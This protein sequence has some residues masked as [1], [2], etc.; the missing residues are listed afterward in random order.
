MS[1][2]YRRN[3]LS[4]WQRAKGKKQLVALGKIKPYAKDDK[5]NSAMFEKLS[6][7]KIKQKDG[8]TDYY[9]HSKYLGNY[10]T[11]KEF[12]KDYPNYI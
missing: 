2:T 7:K 8:S 12:L 11:Y 9:Y 6:T 4:Q 5:N 1:R 3:Y 10:N